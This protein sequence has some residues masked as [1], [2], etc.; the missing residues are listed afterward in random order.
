MPLAPIRIT[1]KRRHK[2]RFLTHLRVHQQGSPPKILP[3][4][5]AVSNLAAGVQE[6]LKLELLPLVLHR[7][8]P[9]FTYRYLTLT[10]RVPSDTLRRKS[11]SQGYPGNFRLSLPANLLRTTTT[12]TL[13]EAFITRTCTYSSWPKVIMA[14]FLVATGSVFAR[15]EEMS[16]LVL[17]S[18]SSKTLSSSYRWSSNMAVVVTSI[19]ETSWITFTR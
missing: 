13:R 6:A 12:I 9:D 7:S 1:V 18:R 17:L 8:W 4:W 16:P 3:Q 5:P 10:D 19:C 14:T 15:S 11:W 2:C